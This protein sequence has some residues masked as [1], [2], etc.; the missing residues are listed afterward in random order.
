[1]IAAAAFPK[2]ARGEFADA[3]LKAQANLPCIAHA[4][5]MLY[6][7]C[8]RRLRG[9]CRRSI[10]PIRKSSA[11]RWSG[12]TSAGGSMRAVRS[13]SRKPGDYFL[14]DVAG[15]SVIVTREGAYLQCLPASRHAH[16]HGA[17]RERSTDASNARITAGPM[18]WTG[19]SSA[20]RIWDDAGFS[21]FDYP[22]HRVACEIWDGHVFLNFADEPAPA[23]GTAR[24]A[25][26]QVRGV[27]HGRAEDAQAHRL[28]R[29]GQLEADHPEL[30]R[31][32][33]LPDGASALE[34][35]DR[36][37]GRGQ[38]GADAQLHRRQHGVSRRRRD[39]ELRRQSGGAITCRA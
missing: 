19:R 12:S 18:G 31:V 22:L 25:A 33:A 26:G 28:R 2:L 23:G 20:R 37:S 14:C 6:L 24:R 16:V 29:Q 17:R 30:Q 13:G 34:P 9:R 39:H 35:P 36:L 21:R 38:S 15:E 8:P 5:V 11:P 1:M 3:T 7:W 27:E 10:T 4:G 32:P